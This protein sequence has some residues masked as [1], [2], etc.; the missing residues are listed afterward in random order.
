[1]IDY[2]NMKREDVLQKAYEKAFA[3]ERDYGNC[4]QSMLATMDDIFGIGGEDSFRSATGFAGGGGLTGEGTCGALVGGFLA[5]G[6]VLGRN[7]ETYETGRGAG[8]AYRAAKKLHDKFREEFGG[9]LCKEVQKKIFGRSF[10]ILDREEYREFERRGAHTDKCTNVV[11]KAA[12]WTAEIILDELK[13][14]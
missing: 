3:Y 6:L 4:A 14:E 13:K 8:R 11:G 5:I 1:M 2:K 12:I 9:V 7:R 10:N